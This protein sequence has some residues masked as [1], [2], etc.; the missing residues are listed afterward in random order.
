MHFHAYKGRYEL[1]HKNHNSVPC[2]QMG[3]AIAFI[4]SLWS[5][6]QQIF[7]NTLQK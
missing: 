1:E 5:Y 2:Q 6:K 7:K 3:V 4:K